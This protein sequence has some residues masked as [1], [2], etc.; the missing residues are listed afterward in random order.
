MKTHDYATHVRALRAISDA[1]DIEPEEVPALLKKLWA[2][3]QAHPFFEDYYAGGWAGK[4]NMGPIEPKL[5]SPVALAVYTH[6]IGLRGHPESYVVS[7]LPD[8]IAGIRWGE[9]T[10]GD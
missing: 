9:R 1:L 6:E 10:L 2:A 7:P 8:L 3:W 4:M 5:Y